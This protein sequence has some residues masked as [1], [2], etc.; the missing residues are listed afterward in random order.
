MQ[1]PVS[2]V[3]LLHELE[4]LGINVKQLRKKTVCLWKASSMPRRKA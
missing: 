2:I 1:E 3:T 4:K